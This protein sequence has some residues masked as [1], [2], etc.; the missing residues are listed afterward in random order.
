MGVVYDAIQSISIDIKN[1]YNIKSLS[2]E[3]EQEIIEYTNNIEENRINRR[4]IT[5]KYKELTNE[6]SNDIDI[7]HKLMKDH[8]E[9]LNQFGYLNS[10]LDDIKL[11]PFKN[12]C[13][14]L[15]NRI[16]ENLVNEKIN[17]HFNNNYKNNKE[18]KFYRFIC[19]IFRT[20]QDII[21]FNNNY[22]ENLNIDNDT[23]RNFLIGNKY[24]MGYF[25]KSRYKTLLKEITDKLIKISNC[26]TDFLKFFYNLNH[27]LN[28][29]C[30]ENNM[31]RIMESW[32]YDEI[33]NNCER[34]NLDSDDDE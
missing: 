22:N 1:L 29:L 2:D 24:T 9:L 13:D 28:Y 32:M 31:T 5:E 6:N 7:K 23:R 34:M 33:L 12:Y 15:N 18:E 19:Y 3:E 11:S 27:H 17:F 21:N 30:D 8:T 14:L 26:E 25:V 16:I 10:E 20:K 4:L